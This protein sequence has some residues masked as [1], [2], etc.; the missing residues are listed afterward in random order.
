M[1]VGPQKHTSTPLGVLARMPRNCARHLMKRLRRMR[2]PCT[3]QLPP[4]PDAAEPSSDA[5]RR[6]S[7]ARSFSLRAQPVTW[8]ER[9]ATRR[10][11]LLLARAHALDTRFS[12]SQHPSMSFT[13]PRAS[14]RGT[15]H[16]DTNV[17]ARLVGRDDSL[18]TVVPVGLQQSVD[19]ETYSLGTACAR[20]ST[21]VP[22]GLRQ[23]VDGETYPL[24][25]LCPSLQQLFQRTK[26]LM[27][28]LLAQLCPS[29]F[30]SQSTGRH[31]PW[32]SLCPSHQRMI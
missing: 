16:M 20:H 19:G 7:A 23:S 26:R 12:P 30:G 6:S 11:A 25:R 3:S 5:T 31:I 29:A 14:K 9:R 21:V 22:V 24:A 13:T 4:R 15:C 17:T 1:G 28:A 32:H 8:I 10:C 27:V 18:S 2:S